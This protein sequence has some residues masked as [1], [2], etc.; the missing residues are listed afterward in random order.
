MRGKKPEKRKC[1]TQLNESRRFS[2]L[3]FGEEDVGGGVTNIRIS[4]DMLC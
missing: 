3:F 1:D 2:F 4:P